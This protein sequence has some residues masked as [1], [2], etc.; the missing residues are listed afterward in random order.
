MSTPG[1][2]TPVVRPEDRPAVVPNPPDAV[3]SVD[4][5]SLTADE[6]RARLDARQR[7]L[8]YHIEALKKEAATIADDVNI[9]GRPLMDRIRERPLVAVAVTAG[10]GALVGSLFGL[11]ARSKRLRARPEDDIDFVRARLAFALDEAAAHVAAGDDPDHAIRRAMKTMPVVYGDTQ[12]GE[13]S[14]ARQAMD[15]AVKTAVGFAIKAAS[16][17]LIRRYTGHDGTLD[18]LTDEDG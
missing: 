16:D 13:P 2:N 12:V 11:R 3:G 9:G 5:D 7:D 18:A 4:L 1:P 17:V 8:Q 14:T 10:V 6:I 15:V